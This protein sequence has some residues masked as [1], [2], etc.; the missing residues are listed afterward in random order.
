MFA[1]VWAVFTVPAIQGSCRAQ[2]S[3]W[4][5]D[6]VV[7]ASSRLSSHM[8]APDSSPRTEFVTLEEGLSQP[9]PLLRRVAELLEFL[10]FLDEGYFSK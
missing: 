1:N 2:A 7:S 5:L 6:S 8:P 3:A 4:E 10:L 9:E